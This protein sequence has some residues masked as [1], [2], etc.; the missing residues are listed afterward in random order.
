MGYKLVKTEKKKVNKEKSKTKKNIQQ[1][2]KKPF[3]IRVEFSKLLTMLAMFQSWIVSFIVLYL[4]VKFNLDS[5]IAGLICT[6]SWAIFLCAVYCYFDKSKMQNCMEIKVKAIKDVYKVTNEKDK[7]L[8][9][10]NEIETVVDNK[11]DEIASEN[12]KDKIN[13]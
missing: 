7:A 6:P 5:I 12:L 2:K 1:D 11:F 8:E 13:L 10:L 4:A 3:L 9:D